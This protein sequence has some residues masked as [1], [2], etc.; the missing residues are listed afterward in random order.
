MSSNP[1]QNDRVIQSHKSHQMHGTYGP[2]G[3]VGTYV[4]D[5]RGFVAELEAGCY[6]AELTYDADP[7]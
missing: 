1:V 5:C 3:T 4:S 6:H 7:A 2:H